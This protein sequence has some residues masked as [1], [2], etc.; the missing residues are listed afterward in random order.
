ME[1][2]ILSL[3]TH[4]ILSKLLKSKIKTKYSTF[5]YDLFFFIFLQG[6]YN[7]HWFFLDF[8]YLK[9]DPHSKAWMI[10]LFGKFE[11]KHISSLF[12][13]VCLLIVGFISILFFED[14]KPIHMKS[15]LRYVLAAI[16]LPLMILNSIYVWNIALN[17]KNKNSFCW[18]FICDYYGRIYSWA[19]LFTFTFFFYIIR[20]LFPIKN[21]IIFA[22]FPIIYFVGLFFWDRG[23][24]ALWRIN[25][26]DYEGFATL[27]GHILRIKVKYMLYLGMSF[28]W[29]SY[30]LPI[31]LSY[32]HNFG[33]KSEKK[34]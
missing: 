22:Y 21:K 16:L 26:E 13:G 3:I 2:P 8:Y 34:I 17:L 5:L 28:V 6:I 10:D 23:Q 18:L 27:F 20:Y 1:I 9:I 29:L 25:L 24:G 19:F 4:F 31:F 33:I 15:K 7:T 14:I 32:M 12:F 30:L 11:L